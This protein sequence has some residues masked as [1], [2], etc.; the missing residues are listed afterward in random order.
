MSKLRK[1]YSLNPETLMYEIAKVPLGKR[2]LKIGV[3]IVSC[4]AVTVLYA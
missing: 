4:L 1:E 3:Y 2:L